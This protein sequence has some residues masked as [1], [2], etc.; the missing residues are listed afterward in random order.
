MCYA[1][2]FTR[3]PSDAMLTKALIRFVNQACSFAIDVSKPCLRMSSVANSA[4]PDLSDEPGRLVE[5]VSM[6]ME[7]KNLC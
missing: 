5:C 1:R 6:G 3:V 4:E 7:E 2:L